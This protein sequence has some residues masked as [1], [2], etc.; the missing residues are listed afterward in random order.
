MTNTIK[1]KEV[2]L[3]KKIRINKD[4]KMQIKRYN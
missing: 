3:Y 1:K 2:I 4:K